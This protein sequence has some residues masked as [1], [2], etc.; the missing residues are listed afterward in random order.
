MKAKS[1]KLQVEFV[2]KKSEIHNVTVDLD[3]PQGYDIKEF[4][5][6][7]FKKDIIEHMESSYWSGYSVC[8]D[9]E[10]TEIIPLWD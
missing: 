10:T 6:E 1:L 8:H 5:I 9:E 3:I 4:N 2:V 7:D